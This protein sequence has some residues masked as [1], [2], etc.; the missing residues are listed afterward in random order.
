MSTGRNRSHFVSRPSLLKAVWSR[1]SLAGKE[2]TC[3]H[4]F[5]FHL[6]E[7]KGFPLLVLVSG[8]AS[9]LKEKGISF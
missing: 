4:S 9:C 2:F 1:E 6:R 8:I 7:R 5:V 3:L